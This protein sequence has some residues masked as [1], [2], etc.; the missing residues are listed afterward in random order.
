MMRFAE[1]RAPRHEDEDI[2]A[3]P[4]PDDPRVEPWLDNLVTLGVIDANG[5]FLKP[6]GK[7]MRG[8][9]QG[10]YLWRLEWEE[11]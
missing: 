11:S 1:H 2:F 7:I 9:S 4:K 8:V 3:H 5:S 10:N 6:R